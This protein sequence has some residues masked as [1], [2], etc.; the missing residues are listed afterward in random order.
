MISR[1]S[2]F[3]RLDKFVMENIKLQISADGIFIK[4]TRPLLMSCS[5]HDLSILELISHSVTQAEPGSQLCLG[6]CKSRAQWDGLNT[7]VTTLRSKQWAQIFNKIGSAYA[8]HLLRNACILQQ[9]ENNYILLSGDIACIQ[10]KRPKEIYIQRSQLFKGK[11]ASLSISA[12]EAVHAALDGVVVTPDNKRALSR[13]I[14]KCIAKYQKLSITSIFRSCVVEHQTRSGGTDILNDQISPAVVANFLFTVSKKFLRPMF[15]LDSFRILKGKL[16]LLLKRNLFE[17]MNHEDL[18]NHFRAMRFKL[19]ADCEFLS[20]VCRLKILKSLMEFLFTSVYLRI[21]D[22]FFY[23]TTTGFSKHK[24]LYFTRMDWNTKTNRFYKEYLKTYGPAE[25]TENFATLRCIPKETGFRVI[26]NCSKLSSHRSRERNKTKAKGTVPR[27]APLDM[28]MERYEDLAEILKSNDVW[29]AQE[30]CGQL[31][32]RAGRHAHCKHGSAEKSQNF[33]SNSINSQV[34]PIVSVMRN[35][36]TNVQKFSLMHHFH[37][38][39]SLQQFM[40]HRSGRMLVM[41]VDL[42]KCFDN[43]PHA[44]LL[45]AVD[46]ALDRDEYYLRDFTV[47]RE[48]RFHS[49]LETRYIRRC[50]DV[51]YPMYMP[52]AQPDD[53]RSFGRSG[54]CVIKENRATVISRAEVFR[55]VEKAIIGSTVLHQNRHYSRTVGIQQGCSI[56]S[57]LCS[58]YF[59]ALDREFPDLDWMVVRY[60]DDFLVVTEDPEHIRKFLAVAESLRD[61]GFIINPDKIS[62]NFD[63]AALEAAGEVKFTSDRVE[64]CGM[65][66][67]DSGVGVKS[68]CKDAYFRFSVSISPF[69]RGA[70]A[71]EKI[72]RTLGIKLSSVCI[73][74][75]NRKFGECIYDALLFAGRRLKVLI[76]RMDFANGRFVDKVL[77]WCVSEAE[78]VVEARGI[79][80]DKEKIRRMAKAAYERCGIRELRVEG[81]RFHDRCRRGRDRRC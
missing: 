59:S 51:L 15:N 32:W 40:R 2:G 46:Q 36:A 78:R 44:E 21:V 49:R 57:Y 26:T 45:C 43:I 70:R 73:N 48:S 30:D 1:L 31:F 80:F 64:W 14:E 24:V 18:S 12:D 3:E 77:E 27:E 19:F 68:V 74:R 72:K 52:E 79:R 66:V 47:V 42:A 5:S 9:I 50:S 4:L 17:S 65:Q 58:I 75:Q 38:G 53:L 63:M 29:H 69:E 25:R 76:L 23:S 71:F 61:K 16:V 8:L 22:F 11:P 28:L 7:T 37:I 39:R 81:R 54:L 10:E 56:S 34:S 62:S 6:Y 20:N 55:K 67:Y 13:R 41:K 35:V 60:V 33:K